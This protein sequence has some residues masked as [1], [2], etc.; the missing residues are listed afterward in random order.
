MAVGCTIVG[1]DTPPVREAIE[2]GRSGLL[3]P[4]HDPSGLASKVVEVLADPASYVSLGREARAI[5]LARYDK[6]SCLA[7]ALDLLGVCQQTAQSGGNA[8]EK[9]PA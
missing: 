5:A 9:D 1:S 4:F 6:D 8:F 7:R 3:T 2:H